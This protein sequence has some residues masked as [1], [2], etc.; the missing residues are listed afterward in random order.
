MTDETT[1]SVAEP[2]PRKISL[3][4]AL[5]L[6]GVIVVVG[7]VGWTWKSM[8]CERIAAQ[9]AKALGE[10]IA[11]SAR[12]QAHTISVF[13]SNLVGRQDWE[14][15]QDYADQVVKQDSIAYVAIVDQKG[16]SVI[17]TNRSLRGKQFVGPA[18]GGDVVDGSEHVMSYTKQ[19]ATVHVGV[20]AGPR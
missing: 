20:K 15:I 18:A 16:V 8:E 2:T 19:I 4:C 14:T 5:I 10:Q 17:H 9:S 6:W 13:G 7:L 12:D 3:K 1:S 11:V